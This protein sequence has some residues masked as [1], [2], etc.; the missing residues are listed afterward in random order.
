MPK[1]LLFAF[2]LALATTSLAGTS[3]QAQQPHPAQKATPAE[4]QDPD[5]QAIHNYLL[6]LDKVQKYAEASKKLREVAAKD[7]A[8][9]A[10]M[11]KITDAEDSTDRQKIGMIAAS[12]HVYVMLRS[13]GLSARDFVMLPMT[14]MTAG[15]ALSTQQQGGPA[16]PFVNPANIKFI[17]DH[18]EDLQ[19][20]GF[21]QREENDDETQ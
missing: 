11:E 3:S 13:A 12:P 19:K 21:V 10:E 20:A 2:I 18:K 9:A 1:Y 5:E 4:D 7:P 17:R 16:P 14:I 8:I 15:F 6:N